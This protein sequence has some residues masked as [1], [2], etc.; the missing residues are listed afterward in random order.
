MSVNSSQF[1]ILVLALALALTGCSRKPDVNTEAAKLEK[2]FPAAAQEAPPPEM[3]PANAAPEP[4]AE[5][6]ASVKAALGAVQAKD[7]G[8][9]VIAVHNAQQLR[10]VTANQLM[11]LESAKQAMMANL[12]D[13]AAQG[14]A[15]AIAELKRIEKTRSQ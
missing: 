9:G 8:E 7:Y 3:A 4:Q 2:A 15:K 6:N 5:V 12:Q 13:R 1:S 14:D 11:A 10:G